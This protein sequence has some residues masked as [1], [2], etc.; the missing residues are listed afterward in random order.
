ME[1]S[2]IPIPKRVVAA[3]G[4]LALCVLAALFALDY[5]IF[6]SPRASF[7]TGS[8]VIAVV[9]APVYLFLQ[10]FAEGVASAYWEAR[11]RWVK[12]LP[13]L[14]MLVFYGAWLWLRL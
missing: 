6:S 5:F 10:F 12:A 13:I 2:E 9:A 8:W 1:R 11:S 7:S 4:L 14:T 3:A